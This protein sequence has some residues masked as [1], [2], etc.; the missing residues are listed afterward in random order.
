M[1]ISYF[2]EAKKV[3]DCHTIKRS[4]YKTLHPDKGGNAEHFKAMSHQY[5]CLIKPGYFDIMIREFNALAAKAATGKKAHDTG[6]K[7][8]PQTEPQDTR[9]NWT[10]YS[11]GSQ[12]G[13]KARSEAQAEA[14]RAKHDAASPEVQARLNAAMKVCIGLDGATVELIG[15]WIWISF[16]AKPSPVVIDTLKATGCKW[17]AQRSKW[18]FAGVPSSGKRGRR[19]TPEEELRKKYG[20]QRVK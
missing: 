19:S 4:L 11:D 8:E 14:S 1:F 17:S 18:Y 12:F 2:M 15:A 16:Q 10:G 9:G 3:E 6:K 20:S 7:A 5:D 13:G